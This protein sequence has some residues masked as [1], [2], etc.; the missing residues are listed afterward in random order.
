M[1]KNLLRMFFDEFA[2]FLMKEAKG[3][4]RYS[5]SFWQCYCTVEE[6]LKGFC[7]GCYQ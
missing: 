3:K 1:G 7:F 2:T 4:E 5:R 6:S